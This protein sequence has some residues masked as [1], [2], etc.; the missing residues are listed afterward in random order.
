MRTAEFIA[1]VARFGWE[2]ADTNRHV[3]FRNRFFSVVRPVALSLNL[4]QGKMDPETVE[5]TAK[6]MGLRWKPR[7]ASPEPRAGIYFDEYR[8]LGLAT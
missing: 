4:Y 3:L 8:R 1:A 2:V 6:C 5:N 7:D